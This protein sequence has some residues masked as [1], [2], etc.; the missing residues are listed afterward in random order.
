MSTTT[1]LLSKTFGEFFTFSSVNEYIRI[2]TPF[3]YPDGDII[4]L[5]LK[6]E[7]EHILLTD[8]GETVGWLLM[9]TLEEDLSPKQYQ[10]IHSICF[11][12]GVEYCRGALTIWLKPSDDLAEAIM[13]LSQ[14]AS[15]VS[16]LWFTFKI[17]ADKQTI[18]A[19]GNAS[20]A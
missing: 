4:D 12:H 16:D 8:L 15:R 14:V 3:I 7:K 9:Q 2:E 11:T 10:L 20:Q 6:E 13:R 19:N 17:G 1:E 5:F 18:D